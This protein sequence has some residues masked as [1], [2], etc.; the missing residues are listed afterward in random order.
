MFRPHQPLIPLSAAFPL[1]GH[2]SPRNPLGGGAL[3]DGAGDP[4]PG[5]THD[6]GHGGDPKGC[7][8]AG[9]V[10]VGSSLCFET[11]RS[12]GPHLL[13]TSPSSQ[14]ANFSFLLT[15]ISVAE[16][17]SMSPRARG[18]PPGD[19]HP[20]GDRRDRRGAQRPDPSK[21]RTRER[22]GLKDW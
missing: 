10:Q 20:A 2:L 19:G 11:Y 6:T 9:L 13:P 8:S 5:P 21:A 17:P 12:G 22:R 18:P 4:C 1:L 15:S 16:R 3:L 14:D 7:V